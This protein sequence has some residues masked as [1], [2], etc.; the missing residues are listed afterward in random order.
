MRSCADCHQKPL[1]YYQWVT[2][3]TTEYQDKELLILEG[4]VN[5][6]FIVAAF[7]AVNFN[8]YQII[9]I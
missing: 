2:K 9:Q 7:E 1:A 3:L 5:L 8:Q 6:D 4:Q